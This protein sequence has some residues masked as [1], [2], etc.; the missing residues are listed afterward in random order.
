MARPS[1]I[2]LVTG[3]GTRIATVCRPVALALSAIIALPAM[4]AAQEAPDT[5]PTDP[6]AE[7]AQSGNALEDAARA[8]VASPGQQ[9]LI[10]SLLSPEAILAQIN[11]A[12]PDLPPKLTGLVSRIASDELESLRPKLEAAMVDSAVKTFTLDEIHALDVFYN[13]PEGRSILLK[14][15]PFLE[16]ALAQVAPEIRAAQDVIL[17]RT[18]EALQLGR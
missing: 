4:L 5:L 1:G 18:V 3:S 14:M 6:P 9:A 15:Q 17:Q 11:A 8:Y 2:D 13:T 10:D 12:S 7:P 16:D